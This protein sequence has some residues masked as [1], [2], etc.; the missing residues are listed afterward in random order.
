MPQSTVAPYAR[1]GGPDWRTNGTNWPN[2]EASEFWRAG[3]FVWHV[4]RT[5]SGPTMLLLHGTGAGTHSWAPM[6]AHLKQDFRLVAVDLPGHGF[7]GTPRG[8]RPSLPNVADALGALLKDLDLEPDIYVGHSAGAAIVLRMAAVQET[9]PRLLISL[10]GAL[11]PF[12]GLMRMIAPITAKAAAFGGLASYLV[13]RNASGESRVRNLVRSV[14]S[15]PEKVDIAPY[16]VLLQS[17]GHIQGALRMMAHWDLSTIVRTYK[18]LDLPV[19]FIAGAKDRAVPPSVSRQAA[20]QA[21]RGTYLKLPD[22]GHLAHEE[23]PE[24]VAT[25]IQEEWVRVTGQN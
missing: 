23:A 19:T 13:S 25:L 12:P 22:L 7:T 14:G 24:I 10:N 8:F 20:G 18:K 21:L 15:D 1:H 9:A 5:G 4:Q 2:K 3:G 6:V 17:R 16:S 11:E